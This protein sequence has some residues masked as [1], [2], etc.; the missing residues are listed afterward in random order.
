MTLSAIKDEIT[1]RLREVRSDSLEFSESEFFSDLRSLTADALGE[2]SMCT[3]AEELEALGNLLEK[4][5]NCWNLCKADTLGDESRDVLFE[6]D[7]ELDPPPSEDDN[8]ED[9]DSEDPEDEDSESDECDEDDDDDEDEDDGDDYDEDDE[10]SQDDEPDEPLNEPKRRFDI[11]IDMKNIEEWYDRLE[12]KGSRLHD[13]KIKMLFNRS[14]SELEGASDRAAL[15]T[16]RSNY[17]KRFKKLD[18]SI[19]RYN[20]MCDAKPYFDSTHRAE[21]LKKPN[22][23]RVVVGCVA[24]L[25]AIGY[26]VITAVSDNQPILALPVWVFG[27]F[28]F[29]LSYLLLGLLYAVVGKASRSISVVRRLSV[30]RLFLAALAVIG[31]LILGMTVPQ[32]APLGAFIATLPFTLGG[33]GVYALYRMKLAS[34]LRQRR[35]DAK[36]KR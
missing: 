17:H 18:K 36:R 15:A 27:L 3:N 26:G 2:V 8:G 34:S 30:A 32:V 21:S 10:A 23:A 20:D 33:L 13:S 28:G 1:K 14:V 6:F 22:T 19:K 7:F 9:D 35:R 5:E 12:G 11:S 16:A 25:T 31:A 24:L 4:I 29:G